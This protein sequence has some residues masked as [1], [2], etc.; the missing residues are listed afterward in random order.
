MTTCTQYR[1]L[2]KRLITV[3]NLMLGKLRNNS[4]ISGSATYFLS[5]ILNAAIPFTLLPILTLYLAP[6]Q[7]GEFAM[8]VTVQVAFTAITGLDVTGAAAIKYYD[9][10]LSH[11]ELKF[12]IGSCFQI[13]AVSQTLFL[14]VL[15]AFQEPVSRLIGLNSQ[16]IIAAACNATANFIIQ[17][18]MYQWQ[19]RKKAWYY[20]VMQV[21]R[22][23]S[24]FVMSLILVV[25]FLQGASGCIWA[26]VITSLIFA[27]VALLS[28]YKDQMLGFAWRPNYIKEALRFG[29]PLIPHALGKFLFALSAR[30]IINVELGLAQVGVYVVAAQLASAMRLLCDGINNAYVPWLFERLNQDDAD[31]KHKIV[32]LT[33]WYFLSVLLM[34]GIAFVVGPPVI[35]LIGGD[36]YAA[37]GAVIGWLALAEA[38][39][40][41][42]VMVTSYIFYSKRTGLLAVVTVSSGL[43]NGALLFLLISL[44]GILGAAMASALAMGVRFLF[45]WFVAQMRHP[46]P[47]FTFK[48]MGTKGNA[49]Q[50]SPHWT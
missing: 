30:A 36:R 21:T 14:I 34:A 10:D 46:M 50:Q 9:V 20:G 24:N 47:W 18:R 16:W 37:S 3:E 44:W 4:L 38:F 6:A 32:N 15:L 41:M 12:F 2:R 8:F 35:R 13:L 26:Q 43:L 39:G 22:S 48:I 42:Y 23:L 45:T 27:Y 11:Q 5:N 1:P 7:Y 19:V 31:Q 28:L 40:G 29:V 49:H 25:I 33:Y 17:M